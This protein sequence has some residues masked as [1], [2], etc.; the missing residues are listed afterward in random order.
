VI[1]LDTLRKEREALKARLADI[2]VE[3]KEM[4]ARVRAVRHREVQTKREIE[5]I[6][7]LIDL[8]ETTIAH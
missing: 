2:E 5:A 1:E 8:Q 6:S 3:S 7:I 4:E